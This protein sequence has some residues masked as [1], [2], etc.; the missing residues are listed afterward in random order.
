M[1]SKKALE[2]LN[3]FSNTD[4]LHHYPFRY[5]DLTHSTIGAIISSRNLY[6]RT[7]K[8]IQKIILQTNSG[9]QELTFFNQPYLVKTLKPG[10]QLSFCGQNYEIVTGQE[11]I[12][13]GRLISIYPETKGVSSKWLRRR[14]YTAL[15]KPIED[16][17]P[18]I[19][20][21]KYHLIDLNPALQ[22]IHF[23][24]NQTE[25]NAATARLAFDE[26]FLL[27][28][29]AARRKKSWQENKLA[30]QFKIDQEK[31]LSLISSLPF[32]LTAGQNLCLKEI[33]ADLGKNQPMNRLLQGE[34]GSGKTVVAAL[35]MY[36]SY[37]N[38]YQS[39]LM[40][41]TVILAQ[42]HYQT[43]KTIFHGTS[44]KIELIIKNCKLKIENCD[45]II[46][47]QA[48]LFK[49]ISSKLGLLVIDEQHRFGVAQRSKLLAAQK[50]TPHLL[51]MTATPIPRTIALT[52][53]SD[54]D[55]SILDEMPI[56]R[57]PVKT[58]I[59]PALKR[60]DAY[61][62]LAKQISAHR[63]QAFIVCPLINPSEHESMADIKNVTEE[64]VK[65]QQIFPKFKLG[66]LHG[67]LKSADKQA[68]LQ[69]FRDQKLQILVST[70][71]IEVGIDFPNAAMIIIEAA[72]RFGLAQLHQLRGRVGRGNQPSYCLLFTTQ[73]KTEVKR[74]KYLETIHSGLKLAE[75][76]LQLRG[77]GNLYGLT[78]HGWL[79][80]KL[81]SFTDVK[82]INLTRKAVAVIMASCRHNQK[83]KFLP[84]E[85]A[86]AAQSLN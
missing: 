50:T 10:L 27:Q 34:V 58:W 70:P 37:L 79:N 45:I 32:N 30:H 5:E 65:L 26:M 60:L 25:I 28:L 85:K 77:P 56:G 80:L 19:I 62:W 33:I 35:A 84:E 7:G 63:T 69:Q 41:P 31:I 73:E 54:L 55:L 44:I 9:N 53:Y 48:L 23:P 38:G 66:L 16:W 64:F 14:I 18:E 59:V 36:L 83:G 21:A 3:I 15:K 46:G 22:Q 42:Q 8:T 82:L 76:D 43:L 52:A 20:K 4:L 39:I 17:L 40:A 2:K 13:T 81:A 24:K 49:K 57:Q 74:L 67:R 6:L 86:N 51:T 29:Q 78:Q 1:L 68:L 72:E 61:H 11:L 75:K 12:H 47:T 71:V